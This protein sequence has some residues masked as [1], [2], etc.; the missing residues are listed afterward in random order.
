MNTSNMASELRSV[1]AEIEIFREPEDVLDQFLNV[2]GMCHWWGAE[3]GLI[4]PE[5]NGAWAMAW[6]VSEAG[7]SYVSS[8]VISEYVPGKS[9][10]IS[11]Y[12]SFNPA[13]PLF[14]PM[15][16]NIQCARSS[17]GTLLK[18]VQNAYQSGPSW[19]W[20]YEATVEC[21]P[22][23]LR[24]LKRYLESN[25]SENFRETIYPQIK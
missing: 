2:D 11:N 18:L 5:V 6:S 15:S 1:S 9:L 24:D 22:M 8:G 7:F 20:Y 23:V 19:D 13:H 21:W 12:I 10:T 16:L 17:S 25:S 4:V 14:G 3:R